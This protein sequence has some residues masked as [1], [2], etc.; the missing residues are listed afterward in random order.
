[1]TPLPLPPFTVLTD[2]R[3]GVVHLRLAGDLDYDSCDELMRRTD[4]CLAGDPDLT[5]LHLDCARLTLC[6]SMGVSTFLLVHRRT[7]ARGIRLHVDNSP[8]FLARLFEVTGIGVV[9]ASGARAPRDGQE[10]ADDGPAPRS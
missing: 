6:D 1:M 4:A 2:A 7:A 3:P 8:P 5:D 10:R 9:F